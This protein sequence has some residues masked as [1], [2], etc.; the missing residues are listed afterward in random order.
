[1]RKMFVWLFLLAG[2]LSFQVR[3]QDAADEV[4]E[5]EMKRYAKMEA[6]VAAFVQGKQSTLE[7]MIKNNQELGGGARYNEIK[8]AWGKADK[9]E[10]INLKEEEKA[11]YE[12]I[13]SFID[14]IGE[15]VKAYMVELIRDNEVLGAATYNKVKKAMNAD[16][17]FKEKMNNL[18]EEM[19]K[20]SA[21]TP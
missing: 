3:A 7:E 17:A 21:E 11:A 2:F 13:Q 6:R 16:P 18:I 12:E 5:E 8:A 10:A 15:E 1:M 19:K 9:L 20:E 14:A 4:T